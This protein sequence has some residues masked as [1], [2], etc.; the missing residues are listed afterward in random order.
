MKA[1]VWIVEAQACAFNSGH[2]ALWL[3]HTESLRLAA[4][5]RPQRARQY[6]FCRYVLRCALS[7]WLYGTA[8]QWQDVVLDGEPGVAPVWQG[9]LLATQR[10][11]YLSLS[12]SATWVGCAVAEAP[13]GIDIELQMDRQR[14]IPAILSWIGSTA[15]SDACMLAPEISQASFL[16]LWCAKEAAFKWASAS[17]RVPSFQ[18]IDTLSEQVAGLPVN[19]FSQSERIAGQDIYWSL[20]T[21]RPV[22]LELHKRFPGDKPQK[23]G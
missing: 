8:S 3:S 2:A 5:A 17:G 22:S 15:E 1:V 12:H 10:P 16:R 11:L 13:I 23:I 21:E 20:C 4:I 14:D 19:L 7:C 6:L 18:E 9:C